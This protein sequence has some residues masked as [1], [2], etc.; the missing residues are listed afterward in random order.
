MSRTSVY[1]LVCALIA[2]S[3]LTSAAW[4]RIVPAKHGLPYLGYL[5]EG[6]VLHQVLWTVRTKSWDN[7]WFF[8]PSL[9]F[10]LSSAV[11]LAY[12]PIYAKIHGHDIV[13]DFPPLVRNDSPYKRQEYYSLVSPSEVIYISRLVV[14]IGGLATV[15]FAGLLAWR[16][17]GVNAGLL[18]GALSGWCPSLVSRSSIVIV[19][20]LA[21]CFAMA[22]LLVA[23]KLCR[24]WQPA[25]S[26][27]SADSNVCSFKGYYAYSLLAG[28]MSGF[29]FACKYPVGAV[30]GAA[31]LAV[32]LS[33]H[34]WVQKLCGWAALALGSF[35]GVLIGMPSL[36]FRFASVVKFQKSQIGMY[37]ARR[38]GPT[39]LDQ[40]LLPGEVGWLLLALTV[41]GLIY[42]LYNRRSRVFT[43]SCIAFTI[44]LLA[45]LLTQHF[46]PL[47]NI[48]CLIPL[49]CV[50][51]AL[52]MAEGLERVGGLIGNWTAHHST[53][54]FALAGVTILVAAGLTNFVKFNA[55]KPIAVQSRTEMMQWAA[56]N[57]TRSS[58]LLVLEDITFAPSELAKIPGTVRQV[59]WQAMEQE[60]TE[61]KYDYVVT[62]SLRLPPLPRNKKPG[63]PSVPEVKL[64][65]L[66]NLLTKL[67][68]R[69][70]F[71]AHDLV[72]ASNLFVNAHVKV[73]MRAV[74]EM[75]AG[76][77]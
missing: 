3:I 76:E 55:K 28:L 58:R 11:I 75:L 24:Q 60:L 73:S 54:W 77:K 33:P 64:N 7:G 49:M 37:A 39:Y 38:S 10:Y 53:R 74:P 63:P 18:A 29:A 32:L 2:V 30:V 31:G 27:D 70:E 69:Q 51:A 4:V 19:D 16:L 14:A 46:Q 8:Y 25:H 67:P 6:H 68:V 40:L 72:L 13:Q 9:P 1:R 5:D 47:R 35:L 34:S 44:V 65:A 41:P 52:V 57:L 36:F 66:K 42:A 71:G 22:A 62:S 20:T 12:A 59:K 45:P 17:H 23:C 43:L 26:A 21:A 50:F 61:H 15:V 56:T 48:L